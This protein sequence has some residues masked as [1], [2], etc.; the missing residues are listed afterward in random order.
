MIEPACLGV[1]LFILA[2]P[3][4][5]LI[6]MYNSL[7][8]K[9]N[10]V[11]NTYASIDVYLKK[12]HDLIPNLVEAVRGY[13]SH[14]RGV[15]E[16]VAA[17]RSRALNPDM[18]AGER[19]QVENELGKALKSLFMNV[20]NYP[21][22]R[23]SENFLALQASLNVLEEQISASRR[24]YNAMVLDYNNAC[25]MIPTSL[26]ASLFSFRRREYFEAASGERVRPDVKGVLGAGDEK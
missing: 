23:A 15:F 2:L 13:M 10:S 22:L 14:E 5:A 6:L 21:E 4:F 18:N 11:R 8:S 9:R 16:I 7:V 1:L 24:A 26:V 3:F 12:R 25:D 20:E 17:L 19:A